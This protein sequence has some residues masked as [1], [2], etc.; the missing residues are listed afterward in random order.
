MARAK[1]TKPPEPPRI[2]LV[3]VRGPVVNWLCGD[4][5]ATSSACAIGITGLFI[6]TDDPP[7]VESQV[8]LG[9][10]IPGEE[11]RARAA[12]RAVVPGRGFTVEFAPMGREERSNLQ[13]LMKYF[14]AYSEETAPAPPPAPDASERAKRRYPRITLSQ[15][16]K[17]A[18]QVERRREVGVANT[19]GQGGLFIAAEQPPPLG[20]TVRLLFDGPGGVILTNATVRDSRPGHGMGVEFGP[21]D[22]ESSKRLTDLLAQVLLGGGL[23]EEEKTETRDSVEDPAAKRR[24][25]R[26]D[27]P[28]GLIVAW[29]WEQGSQ[30]SIAP[31]VGRG[32]LFIATLD[33]APAGTSLRMLFDVPGGEILATGVVRDC[34]PGRGMGI[35][36]TQMGPQEVARLESL[37]HKLLA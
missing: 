18:W 34:R 12:V 15:G 30:M 31:T 21:L 24:F 36:F 8:N 16:L 3:L 4:R 37:L 35:E 11:L 17:V 6:S 26:V 14:P 25:K 9:F 23:G 28:R 33:P 2:R 5:R 32:G 29:S 7:P 19:I 1:K 20:A 27:L 10:E 22:P 13:G